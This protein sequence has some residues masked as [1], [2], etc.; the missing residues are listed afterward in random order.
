MSQRLV[1]MKF[2]GTS[3]G[4]AERFRQCA[5]IVAQAAREDRVIV[6]VSA[7]AGVTDLIFRTLEAAR[8]GNSLSAETH[9]RKFESVH[10]E[11]MATLFNGEQ[12]AAALEF[13]AEVFDRLEDSVRA[14]LALASGISSETTD[15]LVA[16]GERISAW[17]LAG[18]LESQ[19]CPSQ[20]VRAE[21]AIVTDQNFGNAVPDAQ[22]TRDKC[23]RALLPLLEGGAVPVVAG[24]SGSTPDGRTTT[25][26]RGGSDYSATI[27]GAAVAADEVWIWTDVDGVLTA[28]PR[29]CPAATTLPEI[30]FAEAIELSYYGA[31]VIHAKAAYPAADAGFPVWIKNSFRP[32]T[33]GTR[34]SRAPEPMNSP[35]KAVTCVKEAALLTLIAP[36]DVHPVDLWGRLFLRLGQ[37]HIETLFA[38]QSSPEHTLGLVLR[39]EDSA[40]VLRLVQSVFR[41][42]LAQGVLAPVEV[43][44]VAVIAVLGESMKGTCGILGRVFTAVARRQV[45][46]IAV[47]QGASELSICFAVPAPAAVEVVRA[48]HDEFFAGADFAIPVCLRPTIPATT[49]AR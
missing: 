41:I 10:R 12:Q 30:S 8:L 35:V 4:D 5:E 42:E 39:K 21:D 27:I 11:L 26:G 49:G 3:V 37:E 6:V 14:L 32:Q 34:I 23:Q 18:L 31:K 25:L 33:P 22:A 43:N 16:L 2:G 1:V 7:V 20:F 28:D 47:A 15:S 29:I 36:R 46:V 44:H 40:R 48:V 13:L 38:T 24:Y 17:T 9:L 45:S 19:R